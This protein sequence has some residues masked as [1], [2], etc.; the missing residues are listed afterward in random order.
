MLS[1]SVHIGTK[2][3]TKAMEPYVFKRRADG[4]DTLDLV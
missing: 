1:A 2:N 4:K 3:V